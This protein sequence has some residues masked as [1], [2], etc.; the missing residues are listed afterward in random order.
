LVV[1]R[2]RPEGSIGMSASTSPLQSPPHSS[3]DRI[4]WYCPSKIHAL[5]A[6]IH[7]ESTHITDLGTQLKPIIQKWMENSELRTCKD[8][9]EV[10]PPK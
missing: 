9:G 1:E 6:I 10:A 3:T 4:R 7:E 5:P 8:C 2:I